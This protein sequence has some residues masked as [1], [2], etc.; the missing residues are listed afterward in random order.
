MANPRTVYFAPV[1]DSVID[2]MTTG[3]KWSL[4]ST[5]SIDFGVTGGFNG[6]YWNNISSVNQSLENAL[7]TFSIYANIKFVNYGY[8]NS[9]NPI[10]ANHSGVEINLSL[11]GNWTF[12]NSYN[13]WAIGFF[14]S[15][16]YDSYPYS[17]ASGDVYLNIKSQA[18]YLTSYDLGS[19]GWFLLLHELGHTLGLKHPHDN[20]GTGRPTF[21]DLDMHN[22]D[23]DYAT[24]MSYND[25]APWNLVSYDP[26]TPMI[27][28]VLA[29]QYLYGKNYSTNA[30]NTIHTIS[31]YKGFYTTLWDASGD[32][33]IDLSNAN[34]GW[35]VILPDTKLS[36]LV[37]T[38]A[39]LAA[40]TNSLTANYPTTLVWL[41]GNFENV[42]GSK[43]SDL[44][45][46]DSQNNNLNGGSGNDIVWGGSGNDVFD[47]DANSR[48]GDDLFYGG[49]GDDTYVLSSTDD[50]VIEYYNEGDDVIWVDFNYTLSASNVE[51]LKGYGSDGLVLT[52][53][54]DNNKFR[55]T[56]SSDVINGKSGLDTVYYYETLSSISKLTTSFKVNGDYL[57]N[58]ERLI[59]TNVN[60]AL[61]TDGATSAGGIYRL[62]KATFNREPDH[63]GLGYWIAQADA[64]NKSAV[65]MAEDFT[66]STEFQNLYNITTSNNYGAGTDVIGLVS[67]FYQNVLGRAPDLEG[68]NYY[69]G[70]IQTR[71]KTVGRVLAEI[72][73]SQENYV[74][75][76]DLIQNGIQY[77]LWVG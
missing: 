59:F 61:D 7:N 60:I 25:D 52:G 77:D 64:G 6:E 26:A 37:D 48:L 69:S 29:L 18:N 24:I 9:Y 44:I 46:G 20:G 70:V 75:T 13:T 66:W 16:N 8:N 3:Y 73:D 71:E 28:D 23:I 5:R 72:S 35:T 65:Q 42:D 74:N 38:N 55:G 1:Y 32:D 34:E 2:G 30:G 22:M 47:W 12:F 21:D 17:G 41:A 27:L 53:N 10:D 56:E 43:Y 45:T 11:D 40:P 67:G 39:G 36:K 15:P 50:E 58:I 76:I 33:K 49:L 54:S 68:L 51:W 19:A 14:P 62:Y 31:N 4:D 57:F 63:G